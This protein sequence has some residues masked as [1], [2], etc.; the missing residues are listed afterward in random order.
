MSEPIKSG[1]TCLVVAG[2]GQKHSPNVGLTVKVGS[3]QGEHSRFGRVWRCSGDGIKQM[4]DGGGYV[5]TNWADFPAAWLQKIEPP[6][7]PAKTKTKELE[8]G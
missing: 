6:T 5:V 4:G 2:F 7:G 8:H 1:D 3:A